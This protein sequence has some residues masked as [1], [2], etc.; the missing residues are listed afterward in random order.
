MQLVPSL[1]V[2]AGAEN[3]VGAL[4]PSSSIL[5]KIQEEKLRSRYWT[6]LHLFP[7]KQETSPTPTV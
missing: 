5:H 6:K 3:P 2:S 7:L 1:A 4:N